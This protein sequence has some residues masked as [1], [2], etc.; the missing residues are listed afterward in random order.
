MAVTS[1]GWSE[2]YKS[3]RL[4]T[5][6]VGVEV[7]ALSQ[8]QI[9]DIVVGITSIIFPVCVCPRPPPVCA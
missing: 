1:H 8:H 2:A 3:S 4:C 5:E 6:L 7:D 9:E